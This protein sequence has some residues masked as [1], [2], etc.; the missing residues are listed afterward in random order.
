[1]ESESQVMETDRQ[2]IKSEGQVRG[3]ERDGGSSYR[4]SETIIRNSRVKSWKPRVKS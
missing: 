4:N 2:D 1:M 3:I